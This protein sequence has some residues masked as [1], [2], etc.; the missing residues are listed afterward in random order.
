MAEV[1]RPTPQYYE[2]ASVVI[3]DAVAI[4]MDG[5]DP[6]IKSAMDDKKPGEVMQDSKMPTL[7]PMPTANFFVVYGLSFELATQSVGNPA[8]SASGVTALHAIRNIVDPV[9]CGTQLF[10]S[11]LFDELC[12]M[13]YRIAL[14]ESA[15]LKKEMIL[16]MGAFA[17][18]RRG[19]ADDQQVR[20]A[21]AVITFALRAAIPSRGL[22]SNR[23]L[24]FLPLI[25]HSCYD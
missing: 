25:H 24:T 5:G 1:K 21:L 8:A 13:C 12:T 15:A 17:T 16:I 14:S 20:R 11:P 19:S 4:S 3:L 22:T 10:D 2:K 18:S 23:E 9:Y 6:S 7:R